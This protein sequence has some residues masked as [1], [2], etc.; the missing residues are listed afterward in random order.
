M[1]AKLAKA[2][3]GVVLA[4]GL[5]ACADDSPYI[6]PMT[7]AT[8]VVRSNNE[9]AMAIAQG[10]AMAVQAAMI[11]QEIEGSTAL[12]VTDIRSD[13]PKILLVKPTSHAYSVELGS[14]PNGYSWVLV[15]VAPGSTTI[16]LYR[17]DDEVDALTVDVIAQV[18]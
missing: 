2:G 3:I 17:D 10:S 5:I 4:I 11:H 12:E 15:G 16:H 7:K 18:P 9:G 8:P 6:Y 1:F 13:D 14:S